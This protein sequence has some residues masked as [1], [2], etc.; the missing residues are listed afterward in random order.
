MEHTRIDTT[1]RERFMQVVSDELAK[2][3]R[4]EAELRKDERQERA[5]RLHLPIGEAP[6]R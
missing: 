1:V 3:E 6:P 4:Q 2:F 5:A